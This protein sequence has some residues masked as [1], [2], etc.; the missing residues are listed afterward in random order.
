MNIFGGV[1]SVLRMRQNSLKLFAELEIREIPARAPA[2]SYILAPAR[3]TR[4]RLRPP[5]RN[6]PTPSRIY[7]TLT[8]NF[9]IILP[10]EFG[11]FHVNVRIPAVQ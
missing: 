3:A 8:S 2:V 5:L 11:E 9:L 7:H 10:K 4:Y 6:S 1:L